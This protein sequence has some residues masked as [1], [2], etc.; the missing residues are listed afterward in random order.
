MLAIVCC[1]VCSIWAYMINTYSSVGGGGRLALLSLFS[2][3]T[4][5]Q[6]LAI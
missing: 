5:L 4:R 2:F 3:V 6:V 1:M